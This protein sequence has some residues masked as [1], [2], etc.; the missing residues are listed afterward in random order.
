[1]KNKNKTWVE[2]LTESIGW[3]VVLGVASGI[4]LTIAIG[5]Y[6]GLVCL[7]KLIF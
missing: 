5:V 7:A 1:M 3:A 4:V 6:T 2:E